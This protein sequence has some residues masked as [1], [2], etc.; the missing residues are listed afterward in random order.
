MLTV[1]LLVIVHFNDSS[2]FSNS[3]DKS[4]VSSFE[5]EHEDFSDLHHKHRFHVGIFHYLGHLLE[6][7]NQSTD[8]N[9]EHLVIFQF[10]GTKKTVDSSSS[11]NPNYHYQHLFMSVVDAESIVDPPYYLPL[12]QKLK[13]PSSP[14]RAP[15]STI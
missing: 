12:L 11:L 4:A 6:S 9:D 15:P 13:L 5:H 14:L 7:I 2:N 3:L 8:L 10:T 1:Y